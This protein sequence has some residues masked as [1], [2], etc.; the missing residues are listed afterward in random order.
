MENPVPKYQFVVTQPTAYGYDTYVA[1]TLRLTSPPQKGDTFLILVEQD[2]PDQSGLFEVTGAIKRCVG[3]DYHESLIR[4]VPVKLIE[5]EPLCKDTREI[6]N[7]M[8]AWE[9]NQCL[10]T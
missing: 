6:M 4:K 9:Q 2:K 8:I 7:R 10:S 3:I 1:A 5:S